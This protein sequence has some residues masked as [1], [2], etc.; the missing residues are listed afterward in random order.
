MQSVAVIGASADRTK[1]GNKAVRAYQQQGY[2]VFPVSPKATELEGL[3][4]F[5]SINHYVE[6]ANHDS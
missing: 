3:P 5:P 1:Y 4:A 2:Q 6:G